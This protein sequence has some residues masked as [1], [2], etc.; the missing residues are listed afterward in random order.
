MAKKIA[1]TDQAKADVVHRQIL[2]IL[3]A[4]EMDAHLGRAPA[5]M[6]AHVD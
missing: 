1:W 4:V 5:R 2:Q 6:R 3:Q